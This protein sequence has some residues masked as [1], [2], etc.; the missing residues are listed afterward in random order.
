MRL[1]T[2]ALAGAVIAGLVGAVPTAAQAAT[3]AY[4]YHVTCNNNALHETA[5]DLY[6]DGSHQLL[7]VV[8]NTSAAY[9]PDK[10]SWAAWDGTDWN[11]LGYVG[12]SSTTRDDVA[13]SGS[14]TGGF[15]PVL[16]PLEWR[17]TV[18]DSAMGGCTGYVET[19]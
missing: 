18:W 10:I 2:I 5:T 11:L 16:G 12:G 4:I 6:L 13:P 14:L 9:H 7:K 19:T 3:T 8:W 15:A 1:R 17:M